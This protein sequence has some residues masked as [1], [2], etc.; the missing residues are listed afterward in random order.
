MSHE[1]EIINGN[2]SFVSAREVPWHRLGT[3]LDQD[4]M[5]LDTMLKLS[6]LDFVP[7]L[8]PLYVD[9]PDGGQLA[10]PGRQA[11]TRINPVT[12]DLEVLGVVGNRFKAVAPRQ[13][14]LF[15]QDLV[16]EGGLLWQTAGMLRP[17]AKDATIGAQAFYSMKVP[18]S[19]L[20]GGQDAVDMYL[21]VAHG[22]DGS[23]AFTVQ[24][25]PTRVVCKNTLQMALGEKLALRWKMHHGKRI[26]GRL[27]E[28]RDAIKLTFAVRDEFAKEAEKLFAQSYTD[29]EFDRLVKQVWA[30]PAADATDRAKQGYVDLTDKVTYFFR[31]G[32]AN[33]NIRGTKWAAYNAVTEYVDWGTPMR[34]DRQEERRATIAT[35][36]DYRAPKEKAWA[37]LT[38]QKK[39]RVAVGAN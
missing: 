17:V 25:T 15:A 30:P 1:L 14:A 18:E 11:S 9:L 31:E 34:G 29:A 32:S 13:G 36:G 16:D 27:A 4:A 26:E 21:L 7:E 12:G 8:Q 38:A 6:N 10:V 37:L 35:M 33:E 19:I 20:I 5:D 22:F 39:T 3:V 24:I 23:L 28:A 2:A